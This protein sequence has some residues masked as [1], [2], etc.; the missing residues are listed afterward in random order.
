LL[1]ALAKYARRYHKEHMTQKSSFKK[2]K[3]SSVV[4]GR[5]AA[6]GTFILKPASKGGAVSMR[7][8]NTAVKGVMLEIGHRG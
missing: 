1:N 5:S 3:G 2:V 8:A 7:A 4:L 6:T